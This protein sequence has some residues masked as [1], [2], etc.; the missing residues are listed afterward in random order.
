V[1]F[2]CDQVDSN[3]NQMSKKDSYG[4]K[5]EILSIWLELNVLMWEAEKV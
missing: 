2:E 4:D 5:I 1:R 3:V